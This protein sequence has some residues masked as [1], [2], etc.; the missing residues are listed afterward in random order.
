MERYKFLLSRRRDGAQFGPALFE[1]ERFFDFRPGDTN[2]NPDLGHFTGH[3]TKAKRRFE[4]GPVEYIGDKLMPDDKIIRLVE[5]R[6]PSP[7][8]IFIYRDL[9]RVA[10]SFVAR[11][12]NPDDQNWPVSEDHASALRRWEQALTTADALIDRIGLD[13]VCVMKYEQLFNGDIGTC[14]LMFRFLGLRV[15]PGVRRTY[16]A[17]T[18][19]WAARQTR[20]LMLSPHETEFV[21]RHYAR[22]ALSG[23]DLRFEEQLHRLRRE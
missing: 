5:A 23:F 4:H 12:R 16:E 9:L 19:D 7:K 6:F 11:A 13:D 18:A 17:R 3:Y 1:P 2:V 14:E 8:F 10:D 21:E 22:D 15:A 20:P